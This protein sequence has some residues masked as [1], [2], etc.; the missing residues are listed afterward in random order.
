MKKSVTIL[1]Q[2]SIIF[3]F[4]LIGKLIASLIHL[5]IPGSI[6]GLALL[7]T[8]LH[9][10]LIK[11]TRIETGAALLISEMM[12]FFVPALVGFMQHTWLFGMKGLFIL[13]IVISGTAIMMITTGVISEKML[14]R[15]DGETKKWLPRFFY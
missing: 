10:G 3:A 8:S 14:A 6:I 12:L 1:L 9:S 15:E 2:I 13:F 11:L 7:F 4:S 5:P